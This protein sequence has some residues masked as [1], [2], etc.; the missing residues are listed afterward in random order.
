MFRAANTRHD[1]HVATAARLAYRLGYFLLADRKDA[2]S[3]LYQ[4]AARLP[5]TALTQKKRLAK[6]P[7][8]EVHKKLSLTDL[9]LL[10]YL[11]YVC[12][13]PYE[14]M[15]EQEQRDGRR[16]LT[17]EDMI[18]RY[19][20]HLLLLYLEHNSFYAAVGQ[21]SVL[22]DLETSQAER[23]YEILVQGSP[24]HLDTKGDYSVRDAKREI[25]QRLASRFAPF[26]SIR[27]GARREQRFVTMEDSGAH[28]RF[29][30]RCLH[31]LQPV[32]AEGGP[33]GHWH[34]PA[35]FDPT[36][37]GLA[38]LQHDGGE[39]NSRAEQAAEL[40]R[41]HAVVHPCCWARLLRAAGHA[42]SRRRLLL[43]SFNLGQDGDTHPMRHSNRQPPELTSDELDSLTW[44]LAKEARRRSAVFASDL[45][46]SF[47][48]VPYCRWSL[49]ETDTL[50]VT[51]GE[52]ARAL[53]V[54]GRDEEGEVL[55]AVC[56]LQYG[57]DRGEGGGPSAVVLES[58]REFTF[59]VKGMRG[60][61]DGVEVLIRLRETRP[62][63]AAASYLAR[64]FRGLGGARLYG[65]M[66]AAG[67]KVVTLTCAALLTAL[68]AVWWLTRAPRP[69]PPG[70]KAEQPSTSSPSPPPASAAIPAPPQMAPEESGEAEQLTQK[71]GPGAARPP[72]AVRK[73]AGRPGDSGARFS[74]GGGVARPG[75]P[76]LNT[77]GASG[78]GLEGVGLAGVRKVYIDPLSGGPLGEEMRRH[79]SAAL[80]RSG[81]LS[82]IPERPAADA[83]LVGE[84]EESAGRLTVEVRLANVRG[85]VLWRERA[86]VKKREA[87]AALAGAA[88]R[89]VESLLKRLEAETRRE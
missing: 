14:R 54:S 16:T 42:Y 44:A 63:R 85:R 26:V 74:R 30:K 58:G 77:R 72:R 7:K 60:D 34:L 1:P 36:A 70:L 38:E 47:D 59:T 2:L 82:L 4:A 41:L 27:E 39:A 68:F 22:F 29:L 3:V 25:K 19:V 35:G 17:Q 15:Q 67:W 75:E 73:S 45:S 52:G 11:V 84:I 71:S 81:R 89:M 66:P 61:P 57:R 64:R 53:S 5:V 65:R 56:L 13:E 48:G 87:G 6:R 10:Q 24:A 43:P 80:R 46:V 23:L 37:Y 49:S 51:A 55:L 69:T 76:D 18:A 86:F 31:S 40:R 50:K 12:S 88:E 20:K 9:Q 28:F 21:S 83:V 33:G 62:H 78:A 32:P 8:A 79:L